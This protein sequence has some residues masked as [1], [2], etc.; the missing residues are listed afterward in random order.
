[1][2]PEQVPVGLLECLAKRAAARWGERVDAAD[3]VQEAWVVLIRSAR[4]HDPTRKDLLHY[5]LRGVKAR[6]RDVARLACREATFVPEDE[7]Y[8]D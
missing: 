2:D 8:D 5:A 4:T 1:M 3:L 7:D 6:M